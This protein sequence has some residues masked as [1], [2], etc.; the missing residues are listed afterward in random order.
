MQR[1]LAAAALV[2]LGALVVPA[3]PA[4]AHTVSGM[5]ASNWM[6]TLTGIDPSRPGLTARVIEGGSRIEL[7]STGA[8]VTVLGYDGEPYL[9]IGPAGVYENLR[10]PATYLNCSRTGCP[11]PDRADSR[12]QPQW[13]RV[14]N[15]PAAR[16]HDHRIH[17]MGNRLPPNVARAPGR[18]HVQAEWRIELQQAS[19]PVVLTGRL[20][21]IPG[22]SPLP[23]L[24][25]AVALVGVG[26]LFGVARRWRALAGAVGL[27]TA[28]DLYHATATAWSWSGDAV[29][30]ITQLIEANS[31]SIAGWVL[32]LVAV[33]WLRRRRVD[34]LYAAA[35]AGASAVLFTGLFDV[36]V[37]GRSHAPFNGPLAL[38]RATVTVSLGL[39]LG[40]V[41][42]ALAGIGADRLPPADMECTAADL[43]ATLP[44]PA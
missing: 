26:L 43:H 11:V 44:S 16:W 18:A 3:G 24:L 9:R 41:L 27:V 17:W 39:G 32:G 38:D 20:S 1:R 23:W 40:V 2:A 36:S 37:L 15:G 22:P 25:M 19:A 14:S 28:N 10:S 6:T 31:F 33:W 13:D 30:R 21:W 4:S 35:L 34:G 29:F 8:E 5:G 12:A 7:T 42:G